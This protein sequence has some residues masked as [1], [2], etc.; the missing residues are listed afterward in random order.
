MNQLNILDANFQKNENIQY[1]EILEWWEKYRLLY[2][3][4]LLI[5]EV[6]VMITYWKGAKIYGFEF[7]LAQFILFNFAAN[8]FFCF[9]WGLEF[10]LG[11]YYKWFAKN[12]GIRSL[13][14]TIGILISLLISW[15][16]FA[17]L[18]QIYQQY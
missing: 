3:V 14:L 13:F 2:N 17:D 18:L 1:Q 6:L 4:L 5:S 12:D 10:F 9:G 15:S 7:T 11:Y 16:I 8:A